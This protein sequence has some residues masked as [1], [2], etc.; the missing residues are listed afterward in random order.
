MYARLLGIGAIYGFGFTLIKSLFPSP[1]LLLLLTEGPSTEGD[2]AVLGSVYLASGLIAG[3]IAGPL[4]G[5]LLLR[6]RGSETSVGRFS[7]VQSAGADLWRALVLSVGFALLIGLISGLLTMGAY[8]F[9]VLPSGGVL[10]P[11]RPI[12]N[13]NFP[14]GVP[15]LVAWALAR[16]LLPAM[17]AGLLLAPFGGG[18]LY[19]IYASRRLREDTSRNRSFE[20]DF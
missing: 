3:I 18:F 20:E 15:L 13:S 11:L 9:G 17:L 19:R 1:V 14:T 8:Q 5:A 16:D 4:L 6:R 12:R 7:V 10:D 2:L